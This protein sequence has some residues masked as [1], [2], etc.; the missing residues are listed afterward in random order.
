MARLFVV[1]GLMA[2]ALGPETA[3]E[4]LPPFAWP[5]A[6]QVVD[7]DDGRPSPARSVGIDI[8][9]P[10]GTEVR[11]S[12]AGTVIYA[13][14]SLQTYGN[15]VLIRHEG[16]WVTVYGHNDELYVNRGDPVGTGDVIARSGA[17]GFT[18]RPQ[19]YFEIRKGAEPVNPLRYLAR[20]KPQEPEDP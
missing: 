19:L 15:L 11:A 12:L 6:G 17:S 1:L 10:K 4:Y 8:L 20:L 14:R 9:T 2:F 13:D 5:V 3:V 18:A 16:G 7:E